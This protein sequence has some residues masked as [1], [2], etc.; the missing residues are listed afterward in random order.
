MNRFAYRTTSLAVKILSSL[1]KLTLDIHGKENIPSGSI[2]FV[3]NHFTRIETFFLPYHINQ[4]TT[5]PVWSLADYNLFNGALGV[6]LDKVGVVSTR[7]PDRDLLIVKS[8]LTGEATW[9]IY[10]EG[11]MVKSKKIIEK[12]RYMISHSRGKHPPHTGAATLALRTEFCRERLRRMSKEAPDEAKRLMNSFEIDSIEPVLKGN[13]Y[14]VP[15]NITYYPM[16][17]QENIVSSLFTNL[18][19]DMS[20]RTV[21]EIMAEGSMLLS[22]VDVDI[23]FGEPIEIKKYLFKSTIIR[24]ISTR[25][26]TQNWLTRHRVSS[27]P[28]S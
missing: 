22:G 10:P 8:L 9:I 14:I 24:D 26:K 13:T 3:V 5:V 15:V 20:E 21:E 11:R 25:N 16:R 4:L 7:D 17:A 27:F 28:A 2:I 12:G 1:S 6:L 19:K 23:R 18:S